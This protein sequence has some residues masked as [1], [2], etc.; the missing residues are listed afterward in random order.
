MQKIKINGI[1]SAKIKKIR[2][3]N[4]KILKK[5]IPS[6]NNLKNLHCQCK[7]KVCIANARKQKSLH[8]QC[9]NI[10]KLLNFWPRK[11]CLTDFEIARETGLNDYIEM[12]L[13]SFLSITI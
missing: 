12:V 4:A 11:K 1:T 10:P 9:Q 13:C 5:Y 8:S 3:A 2:I 7:K 6:A